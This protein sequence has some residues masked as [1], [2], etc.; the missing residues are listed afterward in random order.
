MCQLQLTMGE[1]F[2]KGKGSTINRLLDISTCPTSKL[3]RF[4][5]C[6]KTTTVNKRSNLYTVMF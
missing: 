1:I 6:N 3:A 2:L 4:A 5:L